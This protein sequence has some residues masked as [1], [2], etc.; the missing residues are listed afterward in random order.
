MRAE[1]IGVR[2]RDAG[3]LRDRPKKIGGRTDS[4][5]PYGLVSTA[6]GGVEPPATSVLVVNPS[7]IISRSLCI[8][9]IA[10]FV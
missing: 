8:S 5:R 9:R 3:G 6:R 7:D 2:G 10:V 1:H 4:H